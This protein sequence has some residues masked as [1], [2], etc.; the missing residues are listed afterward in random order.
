[1]PDLIFRGDP[2]R[3]PP[4]L[5]RHALSH[6][7]ITNAALREPEAGE[8][9][10]KGASRARLVMKILFADDPEVIERVPDPVLVFSPR[11]PE[12]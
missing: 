4:D 6:V 8:M 5:A 11:P 3:A 2:E 9:A 10:W 7:Q 1:M 12:R